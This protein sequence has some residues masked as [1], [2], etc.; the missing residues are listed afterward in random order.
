MGRVGAAV[1]V[2]ALVAAGQAHTAAGGGRQVVRAATH[3][4]VRG[5]T[6]ARLAGRY[7]VATAALASAN[8]LARPDHIRIG[9]VLVIPKDGPRAGVE[10]PRSAPAP[11]PSPRV[12][13]GAAASTYQV[14]EGDTLGAIARRHDTT[15]AELVGANGLVD[16]DRIRA[17]T[18]LAVPGA[19]WICPV[20]GSSRFTDDWGAARDGGR[21][22]LGTDLFAPLGTPVV[23]SVSGTVRHASGARAGL[24][25]YLEGDDGNTYYG[26]HLDG[27]QPPGDVTRGQVIGTV[28][29]TGNASATSPHLHFELKPGGGDP[30]N[31]FFTLQRWCRA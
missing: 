25:Y 9:Q 22:H 6:L 26:A 8:R 18:G 20:Q 30:V 16:P 12:V 23:A 19:G 2:V 4:V 15:V 13:V 29:S 28:G 31:P 11:L 5:D 10:A 1:A 17:G 21:R 24:A 14:V 3:T 7:G 27:L